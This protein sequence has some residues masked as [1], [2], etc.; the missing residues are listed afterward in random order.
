M[1]PYYHTEQGTD[2]TQLVLVCAWVYPNIIP[3]VHEFTLTPYRR[4]SLAAAGVLHGRRT[5]PRLSG[6]RSR[7]KARACC[8]AP[9]MW[10][11]TEQAHSPVLIGGTRAGTRDRRHPR[12]VVGA[13]PGSSC[14]AIHVVE[15]GVG[16]FISCRGIRARR[17]HSL[18]SSCRKWSGAASGHRGLA[19]WG[20]GQS[21]CP[22]RVTTHR[23][24]VAPH[25]AP[26]GL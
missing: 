6:R 11:I 15:F 3:S 7:N 12:L 8:T 1:T 17:F 21:E 26:R 24:G 25:L 23:F 2:G 10:R 19:A 14:K 16:Q 18:G 5:S 4:S 22:I 20:P 13:R 9:A